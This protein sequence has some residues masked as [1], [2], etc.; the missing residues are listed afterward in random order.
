[1]SNLA[2]AV[3]AEAAEETNSDRLPFNLVAGTI[4]SKKS[5]FTKV[6]AFGG[7]DFF[8]GKLSTSAYHTHIRKNGAERLEVVDA[9]LKAGGTDLI[10]LKVIKSDNPEYPVG[11]HIGMYW[12]ELHRHYIKRG[13]SLAP[14]P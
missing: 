10:A 2:Q 14:N 4:F 3:A 5:A 11:T 9:E 8:T 7:R 6:P 1:M 13:P 12:S